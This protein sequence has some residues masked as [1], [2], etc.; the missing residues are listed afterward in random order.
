MGDL[1]YTAHINQVLLTSPSGNHPVP[2]GEGP[3]SLSRYFHQSN[4]FRAV[5][6]SRK[7]ERKGCISEVFQK[8]HMCINEQCDSVGDE[9]LAEPSGFMKSE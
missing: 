8:G 2:R 3:M 4:H 7:V 6:M 5:I 1:P 9:N